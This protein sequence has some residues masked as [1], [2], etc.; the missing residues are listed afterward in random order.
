[1]ADDEPTIQPPND[2]L[3][4][5]VV[6]GGPR[7]RA[8]AASPA[9]WSG[10]EN[11]SLEKPGDEIGPY[12]L[13]SKIGEGGFGT[14]WKAE[15]RTPF[16]QRVALKV[17]KAGMDSSSVLARFEQERQALAVMSHPNIARVLDGGMTAAG[18]PYFAM[19]FVEG[20][21]I[22][23]HCDRH[24]LSLKDR[25][26]LFAQ[27]CD[28]IQHAHTKGVIHR[29]LK[30][31]N[32]L[33]AAGEHDAAQAKVIDFGI[34]KALTNT[35]SGHTVFTEV[36]QTIGTP[37]Y[38]SPEQADPGSSDID[39][40]A[41]VYSLGVI[42]YELL[43]GAPPFDSLEL[44]CKPLRE[45][46]RIIREVDPPTPT[47]RLAAIAKGERRLA[48]RI[49]ASRQ[50][51]P[52]SL[53][54]VLGRELEWIPLMAMRKERGE[55]Y[56]TPNDLA[57][58]LQN[59]LG[60]RPLI[61]AP[62]S[63]AYRVR[64]YVRR[65]RGLVIA[66]SAVASALVIGLGIAT[67]QWSEAKMQAW[68]AS[69]ANTKLRQSLL[70]T[71][72]TAY[73]GSIRRASSANNAADLT[74]LREELR[75]IQA[76]E[77]PGAMDGFAFRYLNAQAHP[78]R[79]VFNGH[80]DHVRCLA[81]SPDGRTLA[82]ASADKSIRL[83]DMANGKQLADLEGH[84]SVVNSVAF[85]PDGRTLA[86]ASDDKTVRLWEVAGGK[87]LVELGEHEI[88][89]NGVAFS[90]DGR[91]LASAG[92]K[93]IKLWDVAGRKLLAELEG[94]KSGV[95]CVAFSPDGRTLAAAYYDKSI[96]L[97]DIASGKQRFS[98]AGHE[99]PVMCVAF[100]PDGKM[101]ASASRDKSIRIWDV[102]AGKQLAELKGSEGLVNCVAFSPDG[103]TVASASH[104]KS[105]R[106]WDV[107]GGK[108]LAEL[109]GH[110]DISF[111]VAFSPDGRSLASAGADKSIRLWDVS[112]EKQLPELRGHVDRVT[113]VAFSPDGRT[114]ASASEDKSIRL[115]DAASGKQLFELD[116][117]ED[118]VTWVAFSPDSRT[119]A[120]AGNDKSIRLWDVS[121]GKSLALLNGNEDW[122][123]CVAFSPDGR[124]LAS[125]GSDRTIRLWEVLGGKLIGEL[126]G[127]EDR[128]SSVAFS[129]DGR[130]IASAGHDK[131]IRL[132][133]VASAKQIARLDGHDDRVACVAF[134][135]DGRT[136]ASASDDKSIRLW[137][138]ASAKQ[139]AR[140]DG[141]DDR[142]TCVA[143]SPD[144]RT[145]ASSSQ[146][147]S[148][149]LWDV[150][151][152]RQ[153]AALVGN[154][155]AL[156]CVAFSPDGA[157]LASTSYDK[158]V[159]LWRGTAAKP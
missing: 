5:T 11:S 83:W 108:Q 13:I 6:P 99:G 62:E 89:V 132:W 49:A 138:V 135:P 159:K 66:A 28:A 136:V 133:D 1:M 116:G 25:L 103:K 122:V 148:I 130:T 128:V 41:D 60:G 91:T 2:P 34:A 126:K 54:R 44:R 78:E 85:S 120:S 9:P 102:A 107:G 98:L 127:H 40:R 36:S 157:S 143:F 72:R 112:G 43:T 46:Q 64:K 57:K 56:A 151:S 45:I 156:F 111:W 26:L 69:E 39:T 42:L 114:I 96:G 154:E 52:E 58:D 141:H 38:M 109:K 84:A 110:E 24:K 59:Y 27:V 88:W 61:A 16:V 95:E 124:T 86:S 15:R 145:L 153:L 53:L 142:V 75:L 18:R 4:E 33:V 74:V 139:I 115:W 121:N 48:D 17:I 37:E 51:Q 80:G 131:S 77:L 100:S 70:E 105:I 10:L 79:A 65:N 81:I 97:W 47:A 90:P 20:E 8:A 152:G 150:D 117:H 29:D 118:R 55:R 87:Q 140:L 147:K 113:C 134:S 23:A 30:P 35:M 125:A 12:H 158:T 71:K 149:R 101:L 21:P 76:L 137:D 31:G 3:A 82:S 19:E 68:L 50:E 14:V 22:T 73:I 155:S 123:D 119:L 67:W 106:L 92:N 93:S 94:R 129:H 144:G 63:T 104:D 32:I 146:D 7:D